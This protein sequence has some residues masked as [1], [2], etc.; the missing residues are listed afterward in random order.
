MGSAVGFE[1][2]DLGCSMQ[3]SRELSCLLGFVGAVKVEIC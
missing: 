2:V 1:V 3:F